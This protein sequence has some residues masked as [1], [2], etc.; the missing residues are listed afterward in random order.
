ELSQRFFTNLTER[1]ILYYL[2]REWPKHLG[3]DKLAHSIGDM[4]LLEHSVRRHCEETTL[5]MRTYSRD[6]LAN[7]V[8]VK[9]RQV[10]RMQTRKFASY[11]IEKINSEMAQRATAS[12]V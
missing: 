7:N 2:D 11:A 8:F 10:T 9:D 5:I 4:S 12:A 6:W 3:G 1:N